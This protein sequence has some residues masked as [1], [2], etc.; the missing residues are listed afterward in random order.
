MFENIR[1]DA[2]RYAEHGGWW[3]HAGF[4]IV[5]VYRFG[6]W[7]DSLPSSLL[8]IPLWIAYRLA[9][10]PLSRFNVELWAGTRG[11]R[12]GPGLCLI[13]PANIMIG[14]EVEIGEDCLV[15]HEVTL[16]TGAIPG[17]PKVGN[18]VDIYVGARIL[19]GVTVGDRCM[20]GAN[21]V[22]TRDVPSDSVVSATP[23]R[24]MP[25]SMSVVSRRGREL[26]E[27][28]EQSPITSS[29]YT[30]TAPVRMRSYKGGSSGT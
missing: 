29:R 9:R 14:R 27:K 8:R 12:I 4:W 25:R 1:R 26:P 3:S 30:G 20:I 7:A 13:H 22:V 10:L 28:S 17:R 15:F 19:G 6:M 24:I 16:A 21:C 23:T 5:A 2:V 18:N 11:A